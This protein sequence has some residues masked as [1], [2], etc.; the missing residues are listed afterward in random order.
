M[1]PDSRAWFD[2]FRYVCSTHPRLLPLGTTGP[3]AVSL[4]IRAKSK[5]TLLARCAIGHTN[6]KAGEDWQAVTIKLSGS[7]LD[8]GPWYAPRLRMFSLGIGNMSGAADVDDVILLGPGGE[9][10][11]VNGDFSQGMQRWFFSSDRDHLPW[12]AKNILVNVLFD[13][14]VFGLAAFLLL[15]AAA[16]WRL[17]LGRA[18]EHELAP[19]LSAAIIGFL[20]VGMFDSL[21]DVPRL[22]LLF[23]ILLFAAFMPNTT[24]KRQ[25]GRAGENSMAS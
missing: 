16:L 18:R 11:L 14:G 2:G 23:Y 4:K 6:V 24:A 20:V 19:Y 10:L 1:I 3:F 5:V 13:Q 25:P 15:T 21:I 22:A 9:S 12:H 7:L 17:N 8:G